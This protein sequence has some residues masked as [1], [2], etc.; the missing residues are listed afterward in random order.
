MS[1]GQKDSKKSIGVIVGVI[2]AVGVSLFAYLMFYVAPETYT[3]RVEVIAVTDDGCI[4]E[5][6]DGFAVNIGDCQAQQGE[7]VYAAIDKKAKDRAAA[8]N[9]TS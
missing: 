5:T 1:I 6:F 3:E 2:A 7:F 8:M 4:A 9:P